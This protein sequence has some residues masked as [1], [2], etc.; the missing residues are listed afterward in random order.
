MDEQYKNGDILPTEKEL[1]EQFF[2][3]RVTVQK[4]MRLLSNEGYISRS[5]GRGTYVT[6]SP[7]GKK[8]A[9]A[10][11]IGVI[12]CNISPSFG[13]ETLLSIEKTA[14]E[15]DYSIILK[16]SMACRELESKHINDL[17]SLGAKG[18]I[19]QPLQGD[20]YS[21]KLIRL[22]LNKFPL[23]LIDRRF[24]GFPIA[25]ISTNNSLATEDLVNHLFVH[26]HNHIG[27]I[28]YYSKNTSSIEARLNGFKSMYFKSSKSVFESNILTTIETP[29]D[30]NAREKN[31]DRITNYLTENSHITAIIASE[32]LVTSLVLEAVTR[33]GKSIPEHYSLVCFDDPSG[34]SHKKITHIKQNESQ[35]GDLAVNLLHK[36]ICNEMTGTSVFVAHT[37]V[38]GNS[39]KTLDAT[40]TLKQRN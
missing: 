40:E 28:C 34:I 32:N 31:I 35:I 12:L 22:Q 27:F 17:T 16:N 24:K 20:Y 7:P 33:M 13:L 23:L 15:L 21:D 5:P 10:N 29:D 25:S 18:L 37:L 9:D 8:S 4:S 1:A 3:S 14:Q 6:Y 26:G 2:T 19:V 36:K 38:L 39:V 11:L 30:L